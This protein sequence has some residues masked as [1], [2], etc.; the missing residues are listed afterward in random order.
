MKYMR[1]IVID[2]DNFDNESI[3]SEESIKQPKK[4]YKKYKPDLSNLNTLSKLEELDELLD[5]RKTALKRL[6]KSL[7]ELREVMPKQH[8]INL[9][10]NM[11]LV[12]QQK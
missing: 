9:N 11:K 7:L 2:F 1:K 6:K 4:K 3:I 5:E 12:I 8:S 10:K